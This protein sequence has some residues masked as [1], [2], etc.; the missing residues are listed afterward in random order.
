MM[1]YAL[2]EHHTEM[3]LVLLCMQVELKAACNAR[4]SKYNSRW[5]HNGKVISPFSQATV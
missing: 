3:I 2:I 1:I 4:N 5:C